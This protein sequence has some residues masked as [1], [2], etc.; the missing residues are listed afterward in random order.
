MKFI[1][2]VTAVAMMAAVA[3]C[4]TSTNTTVQ[5]V[6]DATVAACAFLPAVE[7]VAAILTANASLPATQVAG[8]ICQAVGQMTAHPGASRQVG[9]KAG[10]VVKVGDVTIP[11]KG[12][13]VK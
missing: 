10:V 5:Q 12:E 7:T 1:S 4:N 6:R 8:A 9:E 2:L 13:F 3:G 11:V